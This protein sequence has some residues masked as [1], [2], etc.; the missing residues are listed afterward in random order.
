MKS[1]GRLIVFT[2]ILAALATAC[3]YFFGPDLA[4][5]GFSPVIA[6]ALFSGFI[7]KQKNMSFLLPLLAL[8]ISDA[9]IQFLYSQDL[10]PYAG[11]YSGQLK[12]YA[13]LLS[14]TLVGWALKGRNFSSLMTGAIAAPTVFF[15]ISNFSVWM[16][17]TE[18]LYSK[19]FGGLMTCYEAGLPFYRNSLIATLLF[20]PVILFVFNFLTKKKAVLTLA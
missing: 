13:I 7:I 16:F 17:S 4:W 3:K 9:V 6:I 14:A 5:S 8:F 18:I 11:F 19:S 12:D 20:L 15:L 1:N 2:L 10:F